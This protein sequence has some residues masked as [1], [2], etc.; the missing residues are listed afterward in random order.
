MTQNA[1]DERLSGTRSAT[2]GNNLDHVRRGNLSSVLTLVHE[3]R[4]L[5][6]AELTR[7]TGLNRS[8]IAALVAELV[9]LGLVT[10]V[11]PD[12]TN[13]VGRP[14]SNVLP[15]ATVV[16]ITANP[17]LDAVVVGLVSLG[18]HVLRRVRYDTVRVPSVQEVVNI[19]TAIIEG[20][21]AELQSSYTVIGLGLAVPGLVRND[22]GVVSIAP[23]L[24]W[25]EEPLAE[26]VQQATGYSVRAANDATLGAMAESTYGAGRGVDDLIY[27]NGGASGIGGGVVVDGALLRGASGFA[28]EL[29]H[30][31]V[32]SNGV[33]CHCGASGCL[34]TEV[35]R[36]ALLD[37]CGLETAQ[38]DRLDDVLF[39][40]YTA[41]DA[42]V[43]ELVQRQI[44][45]LGIALRG[46]INVFNPR[47]I[48]LGGFL[49]SLY[50][51]AP[52]LLEQVAIGLAREGVQIRRTELGSD[53][54][55]IGAAQLVFAS[56]LDNPASVVATP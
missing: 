7:A 45:Y 19:V 47:L 9:E 21:R 53:I 22:T 40:R 4:G 8:T 18:G 33:E 17:E 34:E 42:R 26:L 27:L 28:G 11:A 15:S 3:S 56:L 5:S 25:R 41:G 31:L 14:S 10:E 37:A 38:A 51:A 39:E 32:N 29:G 44:G 35:L 50:R 55:T 36:A 43:V 52:A 6:R 16:A 23:H 13:L 20:M 54:L 24:D 46:A 49:G 1:R 12:P 2:R 30:T 48:V